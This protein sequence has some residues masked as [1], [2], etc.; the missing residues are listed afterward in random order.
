MPAQ[1]VSVRFHR[2]LDRSS[3]GDLGDETQIRREAQSHSRPRPAGRKHNPHTSLTLRCARAG[4]HALTSKH[5]K[6]PGCRHDL[7]SSEA[8][9]PQASPSHI[10]PSRQSLSKAD[11]PSPC[12]LTEGEERR[13]RGRIRPVACSHSAA[14]ATM[15]MKTRSLHKAGRWVSAEAQGRRRSPWPHAESQPLKLSP[16]PSRTRGTPVPKVTPSS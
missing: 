8:A 3:T 1:S 7:I 11:S 5:P 4:S 16:S 12:S 13:G 2:R 6:D 10:S 15:G 14:P 9:Q